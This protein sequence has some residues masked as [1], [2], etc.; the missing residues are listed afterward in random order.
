M[1]DRRGRILGSQGSPPVSHAA[2]GTQVANSAPPVLATGAIGCD[3]DGTC[4]GRIFVPSSTTRTP[5]PSAYT[6]PTSGTLPTAPTP[7]PTPSPTGGG[8]IPS[9]EAR[10]TPEVWPGRPYPLGANY[11]GF[12]TNFAIYSEVAERVELCLFAEDGTE[13]RHDLPDMT[14]F[15]WHGYVPAMSPGQRYGFR[16]HGPLSPARGIRRNPV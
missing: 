9:G 12:G 14:G 4:P 13:S 6:A 8:P 15:V 10:E 11:D 3:G 7:L 16:V 5:S 1:T 2:T